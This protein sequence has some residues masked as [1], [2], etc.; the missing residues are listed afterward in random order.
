MRY[1]QNI[2]QHKKLEQIST[3]K[4]IKP[5]FRISFNLKIRNLTKTKNTDLNKNINFEFELAKLEL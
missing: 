5:Y 3:T 4:S 2:S 1:F